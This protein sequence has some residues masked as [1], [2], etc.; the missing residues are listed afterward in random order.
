VT[1]D[2]SGI[3]RIWSAKKKFLREIKFPPEHQIDSVCFVNAE[4]DLLVSHK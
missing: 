4:G 1:S 2:H 3:I